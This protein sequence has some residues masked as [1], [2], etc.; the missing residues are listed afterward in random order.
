MGKHWRTV[1]I[2]HRQAKWS[3]CCMARLEAALPCMPWPRAS[4]GT[5]P[6][7][8][9]RW[10]SGD[11]EPPARE[12]TSSTLTSWTMT[13][14]TC[15]LGFARDILAKRSYWRGF[16]PP[17]GFSLGCAC[18]PSAAGSRAMCV[19]PPI[20]VP[21]CR[22]IGR[23]AGGGSRNPPHRPDHRYTRR[24]HSEGS[25]PPHAVTPSSECLIRACTSP[26]LTSL[27][28]DETLRRPPSGGTSVGRDVRS[29]A[30]TIL[31]R[32]IAQ[33]FARPDRLQI[34]ALPVKS[35]VVHTT[36]NNKIHVILLILSLEAW[37]GH[38]PH[39]RSS[40]DR[41]GRSR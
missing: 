8:Y 16:S 31:S 6:R 4:P 32:R 21:F 30:A 38:N 37:P 20:S 41:G 19:V 33:E 35:P 39:S 7:L 9:T 27:L 12:A 34:H 25:S 40:D 11:T 15:L 36:I 23:G 1:S 5:G 28:L 22:R 24:R 2:P 3:C 17:S 13:W 29:R 14:R 18:W 26:T 10:M